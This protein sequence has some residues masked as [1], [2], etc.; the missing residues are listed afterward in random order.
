MRVLTS[1][2]VAGLIAAAVPPV[3]RAGGSASWLRAYMAAYRSTRSSATNHVLIPAW[4]RKYNMNCSGCHYPAAPR[5]NATSR[6]VAREEGDRAGTPVPFLARSR[7]LG[8]R[9]FSHLPYRVQDITSPCPAQGGR[10][11]R[12]R[13]PQ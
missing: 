7:I 6:L 3:A 12:C 13:L 11:P 5:L 10:N 2:A 4:A 1:L 9:S 8:G